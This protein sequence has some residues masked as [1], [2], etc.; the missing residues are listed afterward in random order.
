MQTISWCH[1][2]SFRISSFICV[3][4]FAKNLINV[5]LGSK[6]TSIVSTYTCSEINVIGSFNFKVSLE[7]FGI[8]GQRFMEILWSVPGFIKR[9]LLN[10]FYT[11]P[12]LICSRKLHNFNKMVNFQSSIEMS[13]NRFT[14]ALE[15]EVHN[16]WEFKINGLASFF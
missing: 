10:M 11:F 6:Y 8:F 15:H 16:A 7:K 5:R 9:M 12:F 14:A 4:F 2:F 3:I 13:I 1:N